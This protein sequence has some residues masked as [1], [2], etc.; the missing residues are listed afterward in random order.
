MTARG[1]N[2]RDASAHGGDARSEH[3]RFALEPTLSHPVRF[4]IVAALAAV[5]SLPF[6]DLRDELA[7]SDSVLS[8]Q[9][10]E[11]ETAGLV[12]A[13]KSFVG[14]RPRTTLSLTADGL[15]RWKRHLEA[16]RAIVG[17]P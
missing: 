5:E 4:S 13:A 2:I 16:M 10:S 6:G 1:G 17:D 3:P 8:K 7:V 14:K 9:I 11:L 15:R 12:R